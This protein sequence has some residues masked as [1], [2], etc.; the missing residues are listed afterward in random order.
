MYLSTE[1]ITRTASDI[2]GRLGSLYNIWQ[3]QILEPLDISTMRTSTIQS[4]SVLCKVQSY[5]MEESPNL[6]RMIGI[7]NGL[8]L[9]ALLNFVP[10]IGLLSIID[11][12][13]SINKYTRCFHYYYLDRMEHLFNSSNQV[14]KRIETL[15]SDNFPT[16]IITEISLGI[17]IVVILQLPPDDKL[18][19]DIDV[20]LEKI[21]DHLQKN[22]KTMVI[23]SDIERLFDRILFTTVYSNIP[24]LIQTNK[25]LDICRNLN[26][27][28]QNSM[29]C[30]LLKYYLT[31][32]KWFFPKYTGENIRYFPL[33]YLQ[34]KANMISELQQ[35][36]FEYYN[37][38]DL[39]IQD[40][41]DQTIVEQKL[42]RHEQ[43]QRFLCSTDLLKSMNPS[44]WDFIRDQLIREH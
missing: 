41:D 24:K 44:Q 7:E 20:E 6:A 33:D 39:G 32:I 27:F 42:V 11:Y 13:Y 10:K 36:K 1:T 8:R 5:G 35:Q 40:G 18:A 29:D 31:P 25:F 9:S 34:A 14:E 38:L 28:K 22:L 15:P 2:S 21:R 17:D 4:Q 26:Q 19:N 43:F 30:Q 37:A 3:D 12:P 23:A 16:H